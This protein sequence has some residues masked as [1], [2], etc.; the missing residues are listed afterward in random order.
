MR[1]FLSDSPDARLQPVEDGVY[2]HIAPQYIEVELRFDIGSERVVFAH[3]LIPVDASAR[4]WLVAAAVS[5]ALTAEALT[6]LSLDGPTDQH[7]R[8]AATRTWPTFVELYDNAVAERD[9]APHFRRMID[10]D[11]ATKETVFVA[12]A[13]DRTAP[14]S[15]LT[16]DPAYQERVSEIFEKSLRCLE[17]L[18]ERSLMTVGNVSR[19]AVSSIV[20]GIKLGMKA[21][22]GWDE[23]LGNLADALAPPPTASTPSSIKEPPLFRYFREQQR[24]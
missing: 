4:R 12:Q 10:S 21:S 2:R 9:S 23:V 19:A 11:D 18:S 1:F 6:A 16:H 5:P 15:R 14:V 17:E 13:F 3:Y 7:F 20:A 8:A 24:R 22:G